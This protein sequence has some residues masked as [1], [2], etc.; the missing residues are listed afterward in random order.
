MFGE[1]PSW[2]IYVRHAKEIKFNNITLTSTKNDFRNAVVLD[3]AH[4][5]TFKEMKITGP[6]VKKKPF[7]YQSTNINF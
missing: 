2:G 3:D 1:L 4:N 7:S 5:C 6:G